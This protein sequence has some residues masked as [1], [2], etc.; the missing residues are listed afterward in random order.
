MVPASHSLATH[1]FYVSKHMANLIDPGTVFTK[2]G[3]FYYGDNYDDGGNVHH[4]LRRSGYEVS[5]YG[6]NLKPNTTGEFVYE[7]RAGQG[8]V[9]QEPRLVRMAFWLFAGDHN[10]IEISRD[11]GKTWATAY[12]DVYMHTSKAEYDLSKY[13][14]GADQRNCW[15]LTIGGLRGIIAT[16][17][18]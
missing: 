12:K 17:G 4:A 11:G 18:E 16:A 5:T 10:K 8:L 14:A 7:F 15:G 9:F 1:S 6:M 3:E 13:M 2:A